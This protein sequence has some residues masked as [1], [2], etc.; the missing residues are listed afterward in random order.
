[1]I[2]TAALLPG[3]KAVWPASHITW[4]S[5]PSGVRVLANHP[6]IDRRLVFDAPT[7]CHLEYERFDLCLS[8]DK[9]PGPTA[10][11]MR[12][13]ATE[14]RG[15]GLSPYG[16]P[17]PLNEECAHYFH[18][19]LSDPLKFRAND[20]SYPQ[21]IYE[22]VGLT[23]RG[24][25][26]R[27]Y[28]S[29]A[30]QARAARRWR[31][32]GVGGEAVVVGL[33]TGAGRVFANKSW[34]ADQFVAL[35]R[36]VREKHGWQIALLGG[37][38]ERALNARIAAV[39]PGV[40][41]TGC[42]HSELEFAALVARCNV[43]VTGDTMAMHVASAAEVPCVVLF[44]PTCHQE[45]DLCGRGE[46]IVTELSCAPCYRRACDETPSCMDSITVERVCAAVKRWVN[47]A[48]TRPVA[49]PV[50]GAGV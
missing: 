37:P 34:S 25:R 36:R 43:V 23:Y 22:A 5:Q 35:A 42:D 8:L 16:T 9:E 26:A 41:D 28:P 11:A 14:K 7:V 39:C 24:E 3:L 21:L 6:L 49:L 33:N 20:K 1:V 45:I 50:V 19:G 40:V 4:V 18:L 27:L 44:G 46:K 29:A 32:L 31:A 17:Y 38:E 10:L 12:V 15:I 47:V 48:P 30:D 13:Q 2:R